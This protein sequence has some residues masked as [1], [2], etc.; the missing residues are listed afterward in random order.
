[1]AFDYPEPVALG[2]P[3]SASLKWTYE[4]VTTGSTYSFSANDKNQNIHVL[5]SYSITAPEVVHRYKKE[6]FLIKAKFFDKDKKLLKGGQLLVQCFLIGPN[7][8]GVKLLMQD[9]G[10]HPDEIPSD[11][12][13]TGIHYFENEENPQGLWTYYVIAQ[14][15]NHAQ[16][17]MTPEEAA[18]IIGGM[19]VTHQLVI[20]F[21]EDECPLI[22]DGNVQV[23]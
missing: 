4:R 15:I 13:Y 16:P 6:P 19:V 7:G 18:Q 10:N 20:T 1:M 22:P 8:E 14:D 23:F 11:G 2:K 9:D 17:D 3:F 21:D 5:S 12:I